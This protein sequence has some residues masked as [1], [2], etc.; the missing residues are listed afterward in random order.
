M[1]TPFCP[2]QSTLKIRLAETTSPKNELSSQFHKVCCTSSSIQP[3]KSN[4][5]STVLPQA[6]GPVRKV[7]KSLILDYLLLSYS[8]TLHSLLAICLPTACLLHAGLVG[9]LPIPIV[10]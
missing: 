7:G 4:A 3:A 6:L 9:Y 10:K 5:E 1:H 2:E 8:M